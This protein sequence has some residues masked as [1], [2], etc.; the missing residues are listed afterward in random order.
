MCDIYIDD[1]KCTEIH[2]IKEGYRI[3]FKNLKDEILCLVLDEESFIDFYK[4]M[5]RRLEVQELIPIYNK[6]EAVQALKGGGK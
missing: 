6:E 2:N 3:V 5:K 4:R 1:V